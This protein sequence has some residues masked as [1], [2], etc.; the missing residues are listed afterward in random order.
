[1][2]AIP[3]SHSRLSRRL[4]NRQTATRMGLGLV[5]LLLNAR[6]TEEAQAILVLLQNYA[7][8]A[9][10]ASYPNMDIIS[11]HLRVASGLRRRVSAP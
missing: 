6:R 11:T 8:R 5:R 7:A 4:H 2:I 9:Q 3:K 10:V 1:M